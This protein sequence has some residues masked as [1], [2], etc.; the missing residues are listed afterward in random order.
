MTRASPSRVNKR[1][2]QDHRMVHKQVKKTAQE[3]AG[4]FYEW[5]ATQK[6]YGDEFYK[7]YP[8]VKAFMKK[9]WPNFVRVAKECMAKQ[10]AD[11]A[12][13][14]H[15]KYLIYEALLNDSTLPYSQQEVQITN[16]RH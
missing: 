8:N 14:E 5:Q 9:D 4:A 12:V 6:R 1:I 2:E 16:F 13:P 7:L 15:E 3:L 10:L 11:P